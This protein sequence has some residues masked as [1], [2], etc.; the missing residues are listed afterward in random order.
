M[1]PSGEVEV[2]GLNGGRNSREIRE[3]IGISLQETRLADKLTVRET[4]TLFRSFYRT[5]PRARRSDPPRF[6]GRESRVLDRQA[7]RR[8]KAA[9]G[10]RLRPGRRS[11][12]AVSR[13][14]DDRPRSA[15]AAAAVGRHRRLTKRPA[16]RSCSRRITWMKPSGSATAWPSSI[17][18]RS[19]RWARRRS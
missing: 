10:G 8:T 9:A 6:A 18:A 14:A 2:L 7:L 19:S 1:R 12:V 17:M 16:A 11:A 4:V 13:R 5:R 3:R 15:V